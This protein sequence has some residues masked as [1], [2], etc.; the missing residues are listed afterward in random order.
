MWA[1]FADF[2]KV[3]VLQL[4]AISEREKEG[5]TFFRSIFTGWRS[6]YPE[7]DKEERMEHLRE[8]LRKFEEPAEFMSEVD[9]SS[10]AFALGIAGGLASLAEEDLDNE[11]KL[12]TVQDILL[13][14]ESL[15][16]DPQLLRIISQMVYTI[17]K[18]QDRLDA[19]EGKKK[20]K[21]KLTLKSI[22]R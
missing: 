20:K 22:K 3:V 7:Q 5:K 14:S 21:K 8:T 9:V 11:D 2:M 15:Q 18:L 6:D 17:A 10:R 13:S 19:T 1:V 4:W 12:V 16:N